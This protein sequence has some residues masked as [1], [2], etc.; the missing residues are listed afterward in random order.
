MSARKSVCMCPCVCNHAHVYHVCGVFRDVMKAVT[1]LMVE[2]REQ[3][4]QETVYMC[5]YFCVSEFTDNIGA[6]EGL[7]VGEG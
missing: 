6:I 3:A 7:T 2:W 1:G 5:I 4:Q